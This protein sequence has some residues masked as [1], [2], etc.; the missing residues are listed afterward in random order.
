MKSLGFLLVLVLMLAAGCESAGGAVVFAPTALPPDQSAMTY[1]HP[2]GAFSLDVPRRWAASE[3]YTT[4]L[5]SVA[6]SPPDSDSAALTV[7]ALRLS[8]AESGGFAAF[9]D[10]YQAELRPDAENYTEVA[11]EPLGD[12]SWR[13]TGYQ[14]MPGGTHAVN[15]F[16]EQDGALVA[17]TEVTLQKGSRWWQDLE[18]AVNSVRLHADHTLQPGDASV[19]AAPLSSTLDIVHTTGWTT[20]DGVF[21]VTGE[22]RNGLPDTVAAFPVEVVLTTAD[23]T[24][25]AGASDLIMSDGVPPGGYA[26]FS[27]RF[28]GGQPE[29]ARSYRVRIGGENWVPQAAPDVI[30]S[31]SLIWTDESGYESDGALVVSGEIRNASD[32]PARAIRA[33]VTVFNA[34]QAVIG[35]ASQI[36]SASLGPGEPI[37]YRFVFQELGGAP[38]QYVV[39]VQGRP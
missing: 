10:R 26:P 35:A 34:E 24:P 21:Y 8:E 18:A 30:G 17:V 37:A 20:P 38:A 2:S 5:A 31:D 15:T 1:T 9:L 14:A 33:T 4:Q 39:N 27:L 28:G 16:I 25:L 13:I 19:L 7:R 32:V 12:G 6:F 36:V 11:R 3:Q 23:G 29:A 22:V